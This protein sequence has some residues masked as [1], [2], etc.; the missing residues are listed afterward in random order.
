MSKPKKQDRQAALLFNKPADPPPCAAKGCTNPVKWSGS[1]WAIFCGTACM[2]RSKS[3]SITSERT[4]N[5]KAL[6]ELEDEY[7][8]DDWRQETQRVVDQVFEK[9]S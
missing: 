8:Y 5:R 4:S 6:E 9:L 2:L 1:S 3:F 7:G